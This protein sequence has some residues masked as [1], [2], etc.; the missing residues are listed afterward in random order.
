MWRGQLNSR[1]AERR[2]GLRAIPPRDQLHHPMDVRGA[3]TRGCLRLGSDGPI[4]R[5][6]FATQGLCAPRQFPLPCRLGCGGI[7]AAVKQA[8]S[9]VNTGGC[10]AELASALPSLAQ[11][12][13]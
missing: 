1:R 5:P 4:S 11:R 2:A 6:R 13:K 8:R 10:R 7:R 3:Q 12:L 9:L